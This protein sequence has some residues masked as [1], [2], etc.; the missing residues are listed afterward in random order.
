MGTDC[1]V[2]SYFD[3][4]PGARD[5]DYTCG[6][7]TYGAHLGTDFRI[8]EGRHQLLEQTYAGD[9]I[10]IKDQGDFPAVHRHRLCQRR[11][12][13]G[14]SVIAQ[15]RLHPP[16]KVCFVLTQNRPGVVLR[17]IVD[18]HNRQ[19]IFGIVTGE[20]GIKRIAHHA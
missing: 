1:W 19:T 4:D 13:S 20:Q 6:S 16:G 17:A 12:L 2:Q 5:I 3:L 7:A 10:G 8:K 14:R 15:K 9:V 18:W 11:R